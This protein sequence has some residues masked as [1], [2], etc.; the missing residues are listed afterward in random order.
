MLEAGSGLLNLA[1]AAFGLKQLSG[2]CFVAGTPLLTPEGSRPIEDFQ[3]GDLVLSRPEDD[4]AG[5]VVA[6]RVDVFQNYS[7]LLEVHVGGQV[8]RTTAEH[9]FW[10]KDRGWVDAHNWWLGTPS[11]A[12]TAGSRGGV[13][14]R[15]D[16]ARTSLQPGSG[17]VSYLL[18]RE[19]PVGV[20]G[21]AHNAR[22]IVG[23]ILGQQRK[24]RGSHSAKHPTFIREDQGPSGHLLLGWFTVLVL[25]KEVG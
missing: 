1:G 23:M 19:R 11:S 16:G 15:S 12:T 25:H 9:P 20:L 4:P 2:S 6:R 24:G 18:R 21:V 7:P 13:G 17:G 5:P 10:V 14:G 8:I 22:R 3:V